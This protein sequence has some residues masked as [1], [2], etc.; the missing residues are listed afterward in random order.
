MK[1]GQIKH[2]LE[3]D[4]RYGNQLAQT[5]VVSEVNRIKSRKEL[6]RL[7]GVFARDYGKRFGEGSQAPEAGIRVNTVRVASY[8]ELDTVSFGHMRKPEGAVNP[9]KK[10]KDIRKCWFVGHKEAL[11]TAFY[12]A[13]DLKPNDVIEAPA[14]VVSPSTTFLVQPG[15][16]LIMN[17]QNA[18]WLLRVDQGN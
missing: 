14:V 3:M 7:I 13:E 8:V 16:R 17:E 12:Q 5:A 18:G 1:A 2:R 9:V 10:S 4:M 11:D 6:L 15:W